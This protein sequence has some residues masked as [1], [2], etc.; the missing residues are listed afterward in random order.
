MDLTGIIRLSNTYGSDPELVLA[1]GGN[2]SVKD[3]ET[4][5]IK[6]SGTSLKTIGEDGFV[7][8]DRALLEQ[9]LTKDYPAD[10]AGREAAF[11]TDVM[12]ARTVP[13]ETRR[14]SVEALLHH[15]FPQRY[16]VH[17]HPAL[18][19]GLTC[20]R[21]GR[22]HTKE[23]FGEKAVWI[24]VI[25]PGF[26]LGKRCHSVMEAHGVQMGEP[27]SLAILENHGIFIA[28]D[29]EEEIGAIL[30]EAIAALK[31]AVSCFPEQMDAEPVDGAAIAEIRRKTGAAH[32]QFRTS[33]Q[34]LAFLQSRETAQDLLVPFTPDQIVYCGAEP[35]YVTDISQIEPD[36]IGGK[37]L[38]V[39]NRGIFA[40]GQ[41][42]KE[43]EL[44]MLVFLDAVKIAIY[45]KSFGGPQPLPEE[46]IQ[47]IVSWEAESYRQK[48]AKK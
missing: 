30:E 47:F 10:D 32:I 4:L 34:I 9:T 13:G 39:E 18:M 3:A 36:S 17:L 48:E 27:V 25:R 11:L 26:V 37:I 23:L 44:A 1:G 22:R 42:E 45:A 24:P 20:G 29:T 35:V 7:P 5:Y 8:L 2:T 28:A 38:L 46:L 6:C 43:T 15:L 40:L 21:E 19:N 16:V 41:S 12:A 31:K 14:P 33:P